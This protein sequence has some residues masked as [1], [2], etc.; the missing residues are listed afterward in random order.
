MSNN[1]HPNLILY[2]GACTQPGRMVM[3]SELMRHGSVEDVISR[4]QRRGVRC[5]SASTCSRTRARGINWLHC[6]NPQIVHRDIKPLQICSSTRN[7]HV[8]VCDFG[9]LAHQ[10]PSRTPSSR[11]VDS[12]PGTPALDGA[13][14]PCSRS[15]STRK[16]DVLL[17]LASSP[18][19]CSLAANPFRRVRTT[20]TSSRRRSVSRACARQFPRL[21]APAPLRPAA[22]VL[23]GRRPKDRPSF[24]RILRHLQALHGSTA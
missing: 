7:W 4:A 2:M 11:D 8:R 12:V 6:S 20:T 21:A 10:G 15:S 19:R 24:E 9:P 3:V 23:G 22:L 17:V 14:G 13:R 16:T 1:H 18:G 5:A